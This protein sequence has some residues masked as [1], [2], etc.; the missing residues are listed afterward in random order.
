[1]F[2]LFSAVLLC[3]CVCL[4][5]CVMCVSVVCVCVCWCVAYIQVRIYTELARS[6]VTWLGRH[7]ITPTP[8]LFLQ[9]SHLYYFQSSPLHTHTHTHSSPYSLCI[10]LRHCVFLAWC[11]VWQL[12]V[13]DYRGLHVI[14]C[15]S[16]DYHLKWWWHAKLILKAFIN[17]FSCGKTCVLVVIN[18][19]IIEHSKRSMIIRTDRD[20]RLSYAMNSVAMHSSAASCSC[21]APTCLDEIA[22]IERIIDSSCRGILPSGQLLKWIVWVEVL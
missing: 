15:S 10:L 21:E 14:K 18:W 20:I 6:D 3:V 13:S 22:P 4:C 11:C 16:M 9:I 2:P 8:Q 19:D 7:L 5:V 17:G 12:A 1:M